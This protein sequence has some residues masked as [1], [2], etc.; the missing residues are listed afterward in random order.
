[1]ITGLVVTLVS[2]GS[3]SSLVIIFAEPLVDSM[4]FPLDSIAPFRDQRNQR[5]RKGAEGTAASEA[6]QQDLRTDT[7]TY[8]RWE[9]VAAVS[10]GLQNFT[11]AISSDERSLPTWLYQTVLLHSPLNNF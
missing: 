8:I 1:M 10:Q 2:Y 5:C 9:M 6:P 3:F 4:V 11:H 7:V